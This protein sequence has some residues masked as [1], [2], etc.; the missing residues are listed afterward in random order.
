MVLFIG[1]ILSIP[2]YPDIDRLFPV[3]A[4]K[5]HIFLYAFI[6]NYLLS[7]LTVKNNIKHYFRVV[8]A[9]LYIHIKASCQ[10]IHLYTAAGPEKSHTIIICYSPA[11]CYILIRLIKSYS[12]HDIP[13]TYFCYII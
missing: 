1:H 10:S 12:F 5:D 7:S 6:K 9:A 4:V 8:I 2:D 13:Y 11:K 3:H